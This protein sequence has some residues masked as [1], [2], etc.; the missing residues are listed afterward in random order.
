ML[1]VISLKGSLRAEPLR[2]IDPGLTDAVPVLVF[3][4]T[5]TDSEP[6]RNIHSSYIHK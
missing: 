2:S 4:E 6:E 3:V 5:L 1:V